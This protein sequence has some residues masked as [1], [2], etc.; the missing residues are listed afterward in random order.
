MKR[1]IVRCLGLLILFSSLKVSAQTQ[2]IKEYNLNFIN[3]SFAGQAVNS[4]Q[5]IDRDGSGHVLGGPID[6]SGLGHPVLAALLPNGDFAGISKKY[7]INISGVSV[8]VIGASIK[9]LYSNTMV[10]ADGYLFTGLMSLDDGSNSSNASILIKTDLAGNVQWAKKLTLPNVD[11]KEIALNISAVEQVVSGKIVLTGYYNY[12]AVKYKNYAVVMRIN[13]SNG[14]IEWHRVMHS[15]N[16]LDDLIPNGVMEDPDYPGDYYIFGNLPSSSAFFIKIKDGLFAP[17]NYGLKMIRVTYNTS[18]TAMIKHDGE[19]ILTGSIESSATGKP[20]RAIYVAKINEDLTEIKDLEGTADK[21][22]RYFYSTGITGQLFANAP[23]GIIEHNER[24]VLTGSKIPYGGPDYRSYTMTLSSSGTILNLKEGISALGSG[25]YDFHNGKNLFNA[26]ESY[27]TGRKPAGSKYR[28]TSYSSDGKTCEQYP[29]STTKAKWNATIKDFPPTFVQVVPKYVNVAVMVSPYTLVVTESCE[30]CDVTAAGVAPITT[31]TGGSSFCSGT[32]IDLIA[33]VGFVS[34]VWFK[35]GEPFGTGSPI[36]ITEG[37]TY[38]VMCYD[39]EGCEIELFIELLEYERCEINYS[40]PHKKFCSLDPP[41]SS[42]VGW[43]TDPLENCNGDYSYNWTLNGDPVPG[44]FAS[45]QATE[46]VGP[47]FYEVNI[48]TPCGT[49]TFSQ[50]VVDDLTIYTNHISALPTFTTYSWG[51][52]VFNMV[53]F[54]SGFDACQWDILNLTTGDSWSVTSG[55]PISMLAPYSS[56]S[57][58]ILRVTLTLTDISKCEIY[59]NTITWSDGPGK[60]VKNRVHK[61]AEEID[62][63]FLLYPNPANTKLNIQLK[64]SENESATV[65]IENASGKEI[66]KTETAQALFSLDTSEFAEGVYFL[67]VLTNGGNL[68]TKKI[69]V[70][71]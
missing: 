26:N 9:R 21:A 36:T 69:V 3:K 10:N 13:P 55:S 43:Y 37:G 5:H 22:S 62:E 14:I 58:D 4:V 47:G 54:S 1:Q 34:Y 51:N 31:S 33:P 15:N 7:T 29:L 18:I 70:Q 53:Y 61:Q 20:R 52:A 32:S 71:H 6:Y 27:V 2:F 19:F 56:G 40:F 38:S 44:M 28:L 50:L 64:L 25:Y 46:F 30:G 24:F 8:D 39:S 59:K 48:T 11:G 60:L 35:D 45:G 17:V 63:E 68:V 41:N 42:W 12:P 49:Q 16:V 65:T 57:G 23:S 67:S 66:Y